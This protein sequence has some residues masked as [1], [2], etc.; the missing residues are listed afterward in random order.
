MKKCVWRASPRDN[1]EYGEITTS[2]NFVKLDVEEKVKRELVTEKG[3]NQGKYRDRTIRKEELHI[4]Y[5]NYD[6]NTDIIRAGDKD[7]YW[8]VVNHTSKQAK[9]VEK[10]RFEEFYSQGNNGVDT[11]VKGDSGL[12]P[13][14]SGPNPEESERQKKKNKEH[15]KRHKK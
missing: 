10:S 8:L 13:K 6:V 3:A 7:K 4:M 15:H 5:P 2:S 1:C 11:K 9:A 12:L 14:G